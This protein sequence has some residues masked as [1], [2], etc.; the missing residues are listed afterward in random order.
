MAMCFRRSKL[1]RVLLFVLATILCISIWFVYLY[2]P[3]FY[4]SSYRLN[5]QFQ[6]LPTF[7]DITQ[8]NISQNRIP[9]KIHQIWKTK[10]LPLVFSH[11]QWQDTYP[12]YVHKIWSDDDIVK[13]IDEEYPWLSEIY[14]S[15][16][17][18]I[19]RADVAR[20]V[21]IYHE[22]GFYADLDCFERKT[23]VLEPL[24]QSDLAVLN[25]PNGMSSNFFFGA[26]ANH[27]FL[28]QLLRTLPHYNRYYVLPYF[29]VIFSTGP[30][31]FSAVLSDWI[32]EH[33][34][35]IYKKSTNRPS[36]SSETVVMSMLD[37]IIIHRP[38]FGRTW[39]G[40]DGMLLN[41]FIDMEYYM[42]LPWILNVLLL[43]W[44]IYRCWR[45]SKMRRN[46]KE[47]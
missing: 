4:K 21:V 38:E 11:I 22:G 16:P 6:E 29:T 34:N 12:N 9:A 41:H 25:C 8:R 33:S 40:I 20:Y 45:I 23:R 26:T 39:Q 3:T 42:L 10:S 19:Q 17:Y 32:L 31:F 36:E 24:R 14:K 28:L 30:Q 27:D 15:Y 1:R 37:Y 18:N 47:R 44:A 2:L 35:T 5:Y 7:E 43:F 46:E 13:L